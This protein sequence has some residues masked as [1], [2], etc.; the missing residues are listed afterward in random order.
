MAVAVGSY[1][2]KHIFELKFILIASYVPDMRSA[3]Y[4]R[5]LKQGVI[6]IEQRLPLIDIE[7]GHSRSARPQGINECA[8]LHQS[9]PAG[10]DEQRR[11]LHARKV[12]RGNDVSGG[13]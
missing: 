2:V 5:H 10:V 3:H 9:S 12:P 7:R 6:G 1:L 8:R 11:G 4:I 13:F